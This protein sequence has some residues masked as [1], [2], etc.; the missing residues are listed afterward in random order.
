MKRAGRERGKDE[1]PRREQFQHYFS[2]EPL[3]HSERREVAATLRGETYRFVTDRG[4]FS[5][6]GID[7]GTRLLIETMEFAPD[8]RVL[9]LG[10][11]Y[12][13]I[14]VAAAKLAPQG[15]VILTDVN[16][17][18]A[19]LAQ[20]NVRRHHIPNAVIVQADGLMP[21]HHEVFDV[22]VCNPPLR[23]GNVIVY[24]LIN[25]ARERLK[26]QGQ[27]WLVAQTK[28]GAKSLLR[29]V[30]EVFGRAEVCAIRGGYRVIRAVR[31]R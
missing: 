27:L 19:Q 10:C 7:A 25:E 31:M 15:F 22:M 18:A 24:R 29:R 26:P 9:D 8:A 30:T 13:A 5:F 20:E 2:R 17:R 3:A 21:F 12:G 1:K 6:E 11:G 16:A 28:Q 4:V 14:G 23:A